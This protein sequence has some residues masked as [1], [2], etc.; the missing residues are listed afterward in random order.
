MS[1]EPDNML[2]DIETSGGSGTKRRDL[3]YLVER[4]EGEL[5]ELWRQLIANGVEVSIVQTMSALFNLVGRRRPD[6]VVMPHHDAQG[7]VGDTREALRALTARQSGIWVVL[8]AEAGVAAQLVV[9]AMRR[10]ASA[11]YSQPYATAEIAIEIQNLVWH[12]MQEPV[13]GPRFASL[14]KREREVLR[15]VI[16]GHTNRE[17]ADE[18]RLSC[19]TVE[20]HRRRVMEKSRARN[21]ADLV[22]LATATGNN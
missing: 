2:R 18:L 4:N 9:D 15:F 13:Y 11:V 21:T 16:A 14:T 20:V 8:L 17:I 22:R 10:G 7:T 3:V 12:Q 5:D 6:V 1:G 19:R